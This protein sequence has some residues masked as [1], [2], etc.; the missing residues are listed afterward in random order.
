MNHQCPTWLIG[1]MLKQNKAEKQHSER[2]RE[3]VYQLGHNA[4][5]LMISSFH[6][7]YSRSSD[8]LGT[9]RA[10]KSWYNKGQHNNTSNG[11]CYSCQL[12]VCSHDYHN[13][14]IH[15]AELQYETKGETNINSIHII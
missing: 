8:T 3:N 1:K 11:L 14:Q 4:S 13:L 15:E 2:Q 9:H 12:T 10:D 6:A 7:A 5:V